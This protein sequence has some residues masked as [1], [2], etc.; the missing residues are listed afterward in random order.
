MNNVIYE[1]YS[2]V[3]VNFTKFYSFPYVEHLSIFLFRLI[4]NFFIPGWLLLTTCILLNEFPF[5]LLS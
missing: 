2:T 4:E 5:S 1:N 3:I